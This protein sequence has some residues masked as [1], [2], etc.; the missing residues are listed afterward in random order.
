MGMTHTM[1]E[2]VAQAMTAHAVTVRP[3]TTVRELHALMLEY[4]IATCPVVTEAGELCGMASR[5][6]VLRA[7]RPTRELNRLEVA[8]VNRLPVREIM[9]R[10]VVTLE[11]GDPLVAAVDL[12]VDSR[13][14]ALPVVRRGAG[15]PVLEG[16]VTQGDVLRHLIGT[17]G[18][19]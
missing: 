15:S 7:L 11:P 6:D 1:T 5:V 3:E 4:G 16:I 10:G 14:H 9:R 13:L 2:T 19:E 12:F 8:E 17:P 18:P